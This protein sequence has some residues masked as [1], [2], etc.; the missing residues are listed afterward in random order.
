MNFYQ[1]IHCFHCKEW[2]K[3]IQKLKINIVSCFSTKIDLGLQDRLKEDLKEQGFALTKPPYTMFS[4]KKKGVS[5]TLY[6]SGALTVQGKDM[7]PFIE[8]YLEPE[9][10]KDFKYSYPLSKANLEDHIGVDEAGKGDFFGPLCVAAV[11]A[12][13]EDIQKLH[14]LGVKDSK[15][16]SDTTVLKIGKEIKKSFLNEVVCIT[17]VKYNDLYFKMKNL[18]HL[19]GWGHATAI[20]NLVERSKCKKVIIDQFAKEHIVENALKKKN[21]SDIDLTQMHR[22]EEDIVVA[23]ASIVARYSFLEQMQKLSDEIGFTLPKGASSLV[24]NVGKKIVTKFGAKKLTEISK[25]HFKTTQ[26]ILLKMSE[27][28]LC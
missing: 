27:Q 18:N 25:S 12:D 16:M 24:V 9:L 1:F 14:S 28:D 4:A 6:E 26:D 3:S 7:G 20:A 10:L 2:L 13:S 22:A 11:F 17:P 5:C 21:V 23:A 8:F 15:R 19:L